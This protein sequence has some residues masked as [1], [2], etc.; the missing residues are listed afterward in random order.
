[1]TVIKLLF[2]DF[3]EVETLSGFTRSLEQ[4][5]KSPG[6]P[7]MVPDQPW[8]NGNMQ[9]YGSVVKAPG[10]PFQMWYT[11]IH[12]PWRHYVC[13]AESDDGF[14]WRK[15][16]LD[17]FEYEGQRTNIV[18]A[19]QPHGTAVLH[20]ADDPREDWRY[21]MVTGSEPSDCICAYHS[22]DGIHWLPVRRFPAI[23]TNPDCPMGFLRAP[24]GRYAVY[25]R[26]AGYGRR[27]F[28]SETWDFTY[29]PGEPRMVLEPGPADD[30]QVQF[31]GMGSAAYGPYE[32]GTLWIYRTRTDD[33]E[34]GKMHGYQ[35]AE[36]AYARSGYAW[37]RA[38][39]GVPFVPHG[40]PGDWD[41]GNLQCASQ[42]VFL[43]NEIRY[44]FMGTDKRHSRRWE[45]DPQKCG[46]G[47]ATMK[48][49]RFVA[50]EAGEEPG[51]LLTMGFGLPAGE[52]LVNARTG[53]EGWVRVELTDAAGKPLSGL[54]LAD[55][56]PVTGD[57]TAQ[58][59]RWR[60]SELLPVGTQVRLR[61]QAQR[62]RLYSLA[63]SRAGR[64]S[65]YRRFSSARP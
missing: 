42:P 16:L 17:V 3:R 48:P 32:I 8:E 45:L 6:G 55:C 41:C 13:Y 52:V 14:E 47:A 58:P 10:R 64:P 2:L 9:L 1:L 50:L 51:E 49:D 35:E 37:H 40:G 29:F 18:F 59:V 63:V 30:P 23:V 39:P 21:K 36:L 7:A 53:E 38:A 61:V 22:A 27:V 54:A 62:A 20:D 60:S 56:L 19:N 65:P 12:R 33:S 28:R 57:T 4:P 25:H 34:T 26:L 5:I 15:P 11:V 31:Y 24:D 44:Y 43:E 46:L